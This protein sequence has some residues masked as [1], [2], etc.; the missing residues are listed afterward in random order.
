MAPSTRFLSETAR[1]RAQPEG[2][3]SATTQEVLAMEPV[4]IAICGVIAVWVIVK[5]GMAIRT[6]REQRRQ[7]DGGE[8]PADDGSNYGAGGIDPGGG[9]CGHGHGGDCGGHGGGHGGS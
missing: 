3:G 9:H 8:R 4:I 5:T 1:E 7:S 6:L 2:P